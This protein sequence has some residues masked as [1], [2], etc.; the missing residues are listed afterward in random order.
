MAKTIRRVAGV[1]ERTGHTGQALEV[2]TGGGCGRGAGLEQRRKDR[3]GAG[4]LPA[5]SHWVLNLCNLGVLCPISEAAIPTGHHGTPPASAHPILRPSRQQTQSVRASCCFLHR[6]LIWRRAGT[7]G[8]PSR[9]GESGN[10]LLAPRHRPDE[11]S[12]LLFFPANQRLH[13]LA[14]PF[15]WPSRALPASQRPRVEW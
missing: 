11:V 15:H 12:W 4:A 7:R 1:I 9:P 5:I 2:T 6:R 13:C 8:L 10:P 14:L 3:G